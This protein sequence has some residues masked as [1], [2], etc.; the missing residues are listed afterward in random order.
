MTTLV[1]APVTQSVESFIDQVE[2]VRL[3]NQI[4][5][6]ETGKADALYMSY[7]EF[8]DANFPAVDGKPDWFEVKKTHKSPELQFVWSRRCSIVDALNSVGHSNANQV[9][10]RIKQ[11]GK[12]IRYPEQAAA[13]KLEA[14]LKAEGELEGE[15]DN[16]STK[17]DRV[18][19]SEKLSALYKQV[20]KADDGSMTVTEM[21]AAMAGLEDAMKALGIEAASV[22]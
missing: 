7:A 3:E 5:D 16:A 11:A 4:I 2:L 1:N 22:A 9:W 13:D 15:G 12:K 20:S 19:V 21:A 8:L 18:K 14:H 6:H 10:S 17:T